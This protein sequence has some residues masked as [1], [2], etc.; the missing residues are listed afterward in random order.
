MDVSV[1]IV[2]WNAREE[3]HDCLRSIFRQTRDVEFEVIVVD[4]ASGD[5]S[6]EMVGR[7]FQQVRLIAN[8]ENL[9]FAAANNQGMSAASGEYY[10]LLNPDT[11][12]LDGAI[13]KA[14]R[15]AESTKDAAVVGCRAYD[16]DGGRQYTCHMFPSL[17]NI[18]LAS[19]GLAGAFPQN[20]FFGRAMMRWTDP[21]ET[22]AVDA[23]GGC[24]MLVRREA[25][26]KAGTLDE[27]YFMYAEEI[28]W[29]YRFRKAGWKVY[30]YPGAEIVHFIGASSKSAER[31]MR[32]ERR[33]SMLTFFGKNRGAAARWGA[34]A[35]FA[36][37]DAL[38]IPALAVMLGARRATGGD[39]AAVRARLSGHAQALGFHVLGLDASTSVPHTMR[40]VL[41]DAAAACVGA[42][43][44]ACGNFPRRIIAKAKGRR[45]DEL[46]ILYYHGVQNYQR[47]EFARQLDVMLE[48]GRPVALD[49]DDEGGDWRPAIAVTF[50]DAFA[51]V[52]RNALP[53]LA[54]R[55]IPATVFV[56][57]GSIGGPPKWQMREGSP[58]SKERVMTAEELLG[59]AGPLVTFGSHTVT[60]RRLGELPDDEALKELADSKAELERILG[61]PV[62]AVAF[63]HGS[64]TRRT[65]ELAR[66]AGYK[67]AYS[68]EPGVSRLKGEEFVRP[69][70]WADLD[71][72]R[73]AH[74]L[75]ARGA[76]ACLAPVQRLLRSLRARRYPAAETKGQ[77]A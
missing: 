68:I 13:Q 46:V 67:R 55:N 29:C 72:W 9:G 70:V 1:I 66:A 39:T 36:L 26:D 19:T 42:A 73:T 37:G 6:A 12:I 32:L 28:D 57:T 63:P 11:V 3:L 58:D 31:D 43:C 33:K 20:R 50:D 56:P 60:H 27:R 5:G 77:K 21:K 62:E 38:R 74:W 51:S 47:E 64:Y 52:L 22:R 30:Y 44:Y 61:T 8:A 59:A 35:L 40:R 17:A 16:G 49:R 76:Y 25:V 4:N 54:R 65:L 34:N 2:N 41:R 71:G 48:A 7:E 69:R 45:A 75:K 15:F 23:V 18:F 14:I 24:F 10:L 53:E